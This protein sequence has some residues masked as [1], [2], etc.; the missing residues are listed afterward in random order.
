MTGPAFLSDEELCR[1]PVHVVARWDGVPLRALDES[2]ECLTEIVVEQVLRGGIEPGAH[3][4]ILALQIGWPRDG[5]GMQSYS[6]THLVGDVEQVRALN[7]WFLDRRPG[8]RLALEHYRGVQP[9]ELSAY[10]RALAGDTLRE[11]VPAF[12]ASGVPELERRVLRY[13]AG[14]V[15][16]WPYHSDDF[17]RY[18]EPPVR[19]PI[20]RECAEAAAALLDRAGKTR[21]L[22]ASV[23]A[24]LEGERCLPRMR[25]LLADPDPEVRAVA[26]GV[27]AEHRDHEALSALARAAEGIDAPFDAAIVVRRLAAWP[28]LGVVEA[29]VAF[30]QSPSAAAICARQALHARTGVWFPFDVA[31]SREAWRRAA[32]RPDAERKAILA[33]LGAAGEQPFTAELG[34][35]E[36]APP[37]LAAARSRLE[38]RLAIEDEQVRAACPEI[39]DEVIAPRAILPVRLTNRA[40]V[41]VS[42]AR[43]PDQAS[44]CWEHGTAGAACE[45]TSGEPFVTLAPGDGLFFWV[46]LPRR[47]IEAA[48]TSREMTLEYRRSARESGQAGW[49][50]DVRVRTQE[51]SSTN[52]PLP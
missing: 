22:A 37:Q 3:M 7:L 8:G 51:T 32:P 49:L 20:L 28:D 12:L 31:T 10:F 17:E 2:H 27:V 52:P 24:E 26:M 30:L 43:C 47:W 50:G 38:A 18:F 4:V 29:L 13:L 41:A 25:A 46:A 5:G 36:Q 16:P 35:V 14:G 42:I 44:L 9:L 40:P 39:A 15:W 21:A 19:G 1:F 45:G 11:Q 23:L 34:D 33:A 6:G 48:H